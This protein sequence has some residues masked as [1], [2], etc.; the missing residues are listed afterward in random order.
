[1]G[2]TLPLCVLMY[3]TIKKRNIYIWTLYMMSVLFSMLNITTETFLKQNYSLSYSR[4]V[5]W[6]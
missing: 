6:I 4:T 1:M 5:L 2:D 3:C